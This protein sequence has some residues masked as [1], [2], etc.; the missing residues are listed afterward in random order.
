MFAICLRKVAQAPRRIKARL[1]FFRPRRKIIV[2]QNQKKC[3]MKKKLFIGIAAVAVAAVAAVNE[4]YALQDN[5]LSALALANVEALARE[6]EE[7]RDSVKV[8][9]WEYI[10]I[11][12][13]TIRVCLPSGNAC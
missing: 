1:E 11:C 7:P 8:G 5:A 13:K 10:V 2:F 9:N 4:S 12:G 6:Q 3:K